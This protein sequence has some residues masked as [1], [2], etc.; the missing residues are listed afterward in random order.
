MFL[1]RWLCSTRK[2]FIQNKCIKLWPKE[3]LV[4]PN[5]HGC[6]PWYVHYLGSNSTHLFKGKTFLEED[7]HVLWWSPVFF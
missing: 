2:N 1:R 5:E 4:F 3:I 7:N 6:V